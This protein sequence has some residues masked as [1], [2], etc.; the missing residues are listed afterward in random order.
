MTVILV[1]GATGLLGSEICRQLRAAGKPVRGLVRETSDPAKVSRL[2]SLG[3][4]LIRGDVRDRASLD[5]A[6]QGVTYVISTVSAM[7]FSYE[8]GVNDLQTTDVEG[9]TNLIEVAKT[10]GVAQFVFTSISRNITVDCPLVWA[11]REVE[12]RLRESGLIYTILQPSYFMEVWLSPAVGFD[13]ANARATIY[14]EGRNP[15]SWI[16]VQD[17][18]KFAIASLGHASTQCATLELGGPEAVSPLEVVRIF[19]EASGRSFEMQFVPME[20]LEAQQA[21]ATD[22]MQQ[23]F[24]GAMRNY[25]LGDRIEMADAFKIFS[26]QS[27]SVQEYTKNVLAVA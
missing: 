26:V 15:I 19:E 8:A 23:S 3:A 4:E 14:G 9:T 25:A 5:R 20:A 13:P 18:A 2:E 16:A 24:F 10:K 21:A 1:A 12:R 17:V 7:P 6:C 22:A 27:T 11:N